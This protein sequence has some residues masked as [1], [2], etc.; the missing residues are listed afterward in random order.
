M[1]KP[2]T[3][4]FCLLPG[5]APLLLMQNICGTLDMLIFNWIYTSTVAVPYQFLILHRDSHS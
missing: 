3:L 4:L 1:E 5:E 2:R